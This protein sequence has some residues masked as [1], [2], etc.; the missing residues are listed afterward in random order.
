VSQQEQN[1]LETLRDAVMKLP[2]AKQDY[3]MG[4]VDAMSDAAKQ[5][6]KTADS[7]EGR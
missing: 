3:V 2:R 4:Y 6:D 5:R 1:R 7:Q